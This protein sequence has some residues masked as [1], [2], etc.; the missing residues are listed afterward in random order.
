MKPML[1]GASLLF[2][3]GCQP[4][5]G[6]QAP[7]QAGAPETT[8]TKPA[9]QESLRRTIPWKP[10]VATTAIISPGKRLALIQYHGARWKLWNLVSARPL[11]ARLPPHMTAAAFIPNSPYLLVNDTD[12]PTG[13][14]LHM[15]DA[16]TGTAE[17]SIIDVI[18]ADA[19]RLRGLAVSADGKRVI[20]GHETGLLC[21]W[22]LDRG[23]LLKAS[24]DR[25]PLFTIR[26]LSDGKHALTQGYASG[27]WDVAKARL[28]KRPDGINYG[29]FLDVS[30]DGK[31]ALVL[32]IRLPDEVTAL[33]LWDLATDRAGT[34]LESHKGRS[35]GWVGAFTAD[36]RNIVSCGGEEAT[37]T[38]RWDVSSGKAVWTVKTGR[39]IGLSADS[40]LA[41]S[42]GQDGTV[43][44]W[45]TVQGRFLRL[46]S[47]GR[48]GTRD[49]AVLEA[50][51][52]MLRS[53]GADTRRAAVEDLAKAGQDAVP[54]LAGALRDPDA[55]VR[56]QAAEG[57][58]AL[59]CKAGAAR[60]P[61]VRA[62][63]DPDRR[64][65]V[66][67]ALALAAVDDK[68]AAVPRVWTTPSA[69]R[70][71]RCAMTRPPRSARLARRRSRTSG[72]RCVTRT[73]RCAAGR[74]T[75]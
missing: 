38:T 7:T 46:L 43:K 23:R 26:L 18:P 41:L 14:C 37:S 42:A 19:G 11:E 52:Q 6:V 61:L 58:G 16:A 15:W 2:L 36:G 65:C 57:L 48:D 17:R 35:H 30:A 75:G 64:C 10:P 68:S 9:L 31:L 5:S 47:A 49:P 56:R 34:T 12:C 39:V 44:L 1:L 53:D 73:P 27:L 69:T 24:E 25:A 20:T 33:E 70:T 22:D 72:A 71:A 67:A 66:A 32:R 60:E 21:L 62:L 4:P 59:G 29:E 40:T 50:L 55:A 54:D 8:K 13:T 74:R 45:D 63:R 51:R 3:L 28:L